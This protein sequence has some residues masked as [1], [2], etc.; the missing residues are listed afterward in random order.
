MTPVFLP[1]TSFAMRANLKDKE[2]DFIQFWKDHQV[3]QNA[4]HPKAAKNFI[5]HVGPPYANGAIH[6]GHA[7]NFIL[8]DVIVKNKR[9]QGY[10][11]PLVAGWDCHGLPIEVKVEED[12]KKKCIQKDTLSKVDFI[13]ACREFAA[14]WIGVQKKGF[15]DLGILFDD[16]YYSTMDPKSETSIMK[17][18]SD[19]LMKGLIYRGQKPVFWSV[20]EQTALAEAEVE[21]QNHISDAIFVAFPIVSG[22]FKGAKAII[23]TTTPWSLPGNRAIA[24]HPDIT[25]GLYD[26]NHGKVIVAKDLFDQIQNLEGI[27]IQSFQGNILEG[28]SCH[29]PFH[30]MGYDF[31]V[32]FLPGDH[33]SA[34]TG[35]GLVHTAPTHGIEDFELGKHHGLE[36]PITIL[37]NGIYADH[38]PLFKGEHVY[39]IN[40][41]IINVL[42]S[43]GLLISHSKLTHSYPHSWRSKKPLI[44]LCTSQWFLNIDAVRGTA[45]EAIKNVHWIP[46]SGENRITAMVA[47]RPDWCLSRQRTWGVPLP[48]I[49]NQHTKE[50]LKDPKVQENILHIIQQEGVEAWF[51]RPVSDFLNDEYDA[52]LYEKVEDIVDVW[53]DSASTHDFVLNS[54]DFKLSHGPADLYLEGSDQHRGW[55]QSS[56]IHSC[57]TTGRAPYKA[58]LTHGFLLDEKGQKMS[59]SLGNVVVPHDYPADLLRLWTVLSDYQ[60]DVRIGKT[61]MTHV[62]DVYRRIRNTFRYLLGALKGY[63]IPHKTVTDLHVYEQFIC[64]HI[65]DISQNHHIMMDSYDFLTFYQKLH[66]FCNTTL[67]AFY[68]DI[69]KDSLYCDAET[70]LHRQ[71]ARDTFYLLLLALLKYW[72]PVLSFTCEEVFQIFKTD[73]ILDSHV[74]SVFL[75]DFDAALLSHP[76]GCFIKKNDALAK[77]F[78]DLFRIRSIANGAIEKKRADK[79]I[80][81]SL[82]AVVKLKTPDFDERLLSYDLKSLLM[83]SDITITQG[84]EEVDISLGSLQKCPRCWKYEVQNH[85]LQCQR[86]QKV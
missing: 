82:Q 42:Q 6:S 27:C 2:K 74:S 79:I 32:P 17:N 72:S 63:T 41:K 61:I 19:L 4:Q 33:V 85:D 53:F 62:E 50:P 48:I 34:D 64:H 77:D 12:F 26:T 69:R 59:K 43:L 14:H 70:S 71:G 67:S 68:F 1:Q 29:H 15:E 36:V 7:F 10:H 81:S 56:L 8:K 44:F 76:L 5:L 80:T 37:G 60:E 54:G 45:L 57:A 23:W 78:D 18:L 84:P 22:P 38:V 20:V 55:F 52:S 51:T 35:T 58:V 83:V 28:T 9:L 30:S 40:P 66:H 73:I 39:K 47:N 25:Y 65:H 86:C 75:F 16:H 46:K 3:Y 11:A 13:K 21:Y 24:Y 49:M 31:D